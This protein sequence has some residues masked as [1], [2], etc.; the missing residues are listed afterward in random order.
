MLLTEV[1]RKEWDPGI[2]NQMDMTLV[3]SATGMEGPKNHLANQELRERMQWDPGVTVSLYCWLDTLTV[4]SE[5]VTPF[6]CTHILELATCQNQVI[7]A[8][9]VWDPEIAF[10]YQ[11]DVLKIYN[12]KN[13]LS[14]QNY[15]QILEID[16]IFITF[17][18]P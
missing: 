9:Y 13:L 18:P 5:I 4:W 15:L 6:F 8:S 2:L 17:L 10:V 11:Q 16:I 12:T 3:F 1:R 7:T 14:S